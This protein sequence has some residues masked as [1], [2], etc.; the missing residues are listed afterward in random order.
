MGQNSKIEWTH[1]TFNPWWGCVKVSKA[2]DHCYAETWAKRVGADVWGNKAPRRFFTDNHWAQPL[3]WNKVAAEEGERKRVFCA[4]MADVFEKRGDLDA[5]RERLWKLIEATPYLDW[6][7]LTKR[8]QYIQKMA[9]WGDAWPHNVWIGTT[10]E[11]QACARQRLK[12]LL[13]IPATVRFLSCEPLLEKLDL[14]ELASEEP[15]DIDWIIAGVES[16]PHSR[17]MQPGWVETLRLQSEEMQAAFHF[18]QWG[19]WS[20]VEDPTMRIHIEAEG[21]NGKPI[22]MEP[23]GKKKGGRVFLG[24]TWDGIPSLEKVQKVA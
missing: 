22:L 17:P 20:P 15:Y 3:R 19:H 11:S 24:R 7:L 5:S 2:C 14:I 13:K 6:L 1:H 10:V 16:G 4:S 23:V 21:V 12:H 9:P 18:K 8:P